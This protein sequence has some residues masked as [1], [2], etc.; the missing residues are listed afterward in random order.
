MPS[1]AYGFAINSEYFLK[2]CNFTYVVYY[3]HLRAPSAFGGIAD[4]AGLAADQ[5]PSPMDP[6][7][8]FVSRSV[9]CQ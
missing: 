4:M 2:E 1:R 3:T 7:R 8:T 9:A 6:V 5:T